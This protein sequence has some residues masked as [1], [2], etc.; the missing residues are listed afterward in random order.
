MKGTIRARLTAVL[1]ALAMG[2]TACGGGGTD[3]V[4][5]PSVPTGVLAAVSISLGDV[6]IEAEQV[7]A[8]TGV[9]VVPRGRIVFADATCARDEDGDGLTVRADGQFLETLQR[10]RLQM[11]VTEHEVDPTE[12][13][14]EILVG[15]PD[16]GLALVSA[17]SPAIG[18]GLVSIEGVYEPRTER[19]P[20]MERLVGGVFRLIVR[21]PA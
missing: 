9:F 16:Q 5:L 4:A 19:V 18:A 11:T 13:N 10:A 21:C 12:G 7:E 6:A 2:A 8:G 15:A 14:L 3:V 1:A 20:L 17:V